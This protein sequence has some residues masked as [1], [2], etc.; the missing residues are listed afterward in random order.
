MNT[1]TKRALCP[2]YFLDEVRLKNIF[3]KFFEKS[4]DIFKK[5]DI[6]D[7]VKRESRMTNKK[8]VATYPPYERRKL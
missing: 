8:W 2:F 3:K 4:I 6:I 1:K 5:S 7:N